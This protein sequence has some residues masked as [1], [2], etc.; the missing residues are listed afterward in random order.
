MGPVTKRFFAEGDEQ[1]ATEYEHVDLSGGAL[2]APKIEFDSF[3][4]V[5]R[6]RRP[7]VAV[8][9]IL[10]LLIVGGVAWKGGRRLP[11]VRSWVAAAIHA[12][13]V[14]DTQNAQAATRP[15]A[16]PLESPP[17]SAAPVESPTRRPSENENGEATGETADLPAP[18][19]HAAVEAR[20]EI[21]ANDPPPARSSARSSHRSRP[22]PL[23]GYV[24]SPTAQ[25]LVPA[26]D[27]PDES[28]PGANVTSTPEP[29]A[30]PAQTNPPPID[31]SPRPT[32]P[33]PIVQ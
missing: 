18:P 16:P 3:D 6:K 11:R 10:S 20:D 19:T 24:W 22:K 9:S 29:S 5:P 31:Q 12:P 7:L 1:E 25:A 30:A 17:A 33:A 8:V 27:S 28:R 26:D 23:R 2:D 15:I 13:A 32:D 21:A 14:A 4:K